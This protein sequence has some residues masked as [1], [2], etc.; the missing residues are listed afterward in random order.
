MEVDQRD[1]SESNV[2]ESK[3]STISAMAGGSVD[4][5]SAFGTVFN[6]RSSDGPNGPGNQSLADLGSEARPQPSN[7]EVHTTATGTV[8]ASLAHIMSAYMPSNRV[9]RFLST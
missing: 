8:A 4:L 3:G 5:R 6:T 1:R 2:G 9:E 7:E